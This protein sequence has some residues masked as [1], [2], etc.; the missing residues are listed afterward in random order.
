MLF[1]AKIIK[2][3]TRIVINLMMNDARTHISNDNR[4]SFRVGLKEYIIHSQ[5]WNFTNVSFS[6][7][8]NHLKEIIIIFILIE[9]NT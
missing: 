3:T 4:L 5:Y 7:F 1:N 2:V 6:V 8:V 9:L